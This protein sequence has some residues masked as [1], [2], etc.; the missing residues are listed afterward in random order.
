[1]N[2]WV[3]LVTTVHV[4]LC[5]VALL[6]GARAVYRY[7]LVGRKP[8]KES[9][10]LYTALTAT[11]TGF[12]LPFHGVTPAILIGLISI[13][14][15]IATLLARTQIS[16]GKQTLVAIFVTGL[17]TSEYLLVFVTIAQAFTKVKALHALAP[18]LN[19]APFLLIQGL[20][21]AL[22]VQLTALSIRRLTVH[23]I[24]EGP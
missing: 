7:A 11:L 17:M 12:G 16:S 22:F 23:R 18:T 15:L 20:A 2:I 13:A 1:M 8:S 4:A 5:L 3:V 9:A 14:V 21:L 19:E 6:L 24:A 10:F